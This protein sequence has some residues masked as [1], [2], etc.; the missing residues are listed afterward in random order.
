[1]GFEKSRLFSVK[2]LGAQDTDLLVVLN[3]LNET[4]GA[5]AWSV[6]IDQVAVAGSPSTEAGVNARVLYPAV[7]RPA[8]IAV[9]VG[10][11]GVPAQ[12]G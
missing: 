9:V 4:L 11:G 7:V 3:A 12:I 10:R 2:T 1:M 8:E 5:D 6:R